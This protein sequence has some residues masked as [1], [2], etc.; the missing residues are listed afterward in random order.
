MCWVSF[1]WDSILTELE[2][3]YSTHLSFFFSFIAFFL[4]FLRLHNIPFCS[5]TIFHLSIHPS[6]NI[7][8]CWVPASVL[9]E[10]YPE[11]QYLGFMV[12]LLRTF[13]GIAICFS[14]MQ[15]FII[16]QTQHKHSTL[17]YPYKHIIFCLFFL[18]NS[19]SNLC[20]TS[21]WFFYAVL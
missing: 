12:C 8:L 4:L 10:S 16:P 11:V 6:M 17:P 19:Q 3:F 13:S 5:Y 21:L 2:Y 9:L 1:Q 20:A 14:Y 7:V 18:T 15:Q